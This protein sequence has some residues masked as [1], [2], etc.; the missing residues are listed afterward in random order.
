MSVGF[1]VMVKLEE[2]NTA[3]FVGGSVTKGGCD[4]ASAEGIFA[5]MN[6][7]GHWIVSTD[8]GTA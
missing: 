7:S 8:L 2:E 3:A 1:S 5:F 4:I 6:S